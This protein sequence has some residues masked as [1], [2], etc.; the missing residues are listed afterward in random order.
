MTNDKTHPTAADAQGVGE[1]PKAV[2]EGEL[3]LGLC[4]EDDRRLHATIMRKEI[5][6][7]VTVLLSDCATMPRGHDVIM[8][9]GTHPT[10]ST[11]AGLTEAARLTDTQIE[12]GRRETFSTDN[13]YCPCDS[14][15]MRKAVRWAERA[16]AEKWNVR[17]DGGAAK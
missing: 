13:P 2:A 14:K 16:C 9:I 8:R 6:G 12:E 7:H 17:L 1:A 15:T 11:T 3:Y 10:A 4:L 5:N